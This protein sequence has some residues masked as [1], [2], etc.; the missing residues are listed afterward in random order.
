MITHKC[1]CY[2]GLVPDGEYGTR[3][4]EACGGAG[5]Y[6]EHHVGGYDPCA[7]C[8]ADRLLQDFHQAQETAT[9]IDAACKSILGQAEPVGRPVHLPAKGSWSSSDFTTPI[10]FDWKL[11]YCTNHDEGSPHND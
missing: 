9:A 7:A 2:G 1:H 5:F 3:D 4:H 8:D 11:V 6:C 10:D